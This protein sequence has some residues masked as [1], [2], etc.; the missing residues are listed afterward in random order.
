MQ[1]ARFT[2]SRLHIAITSATGAGSER[3][4]KRRS[5]MQESCGRQH[6]PIS[7]FVFM[8]DAIPR[9]SAKQD[10][11]ICVL[12]ACTTSSRCSPAPRHALHWRC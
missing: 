1:G 6:S 2:F 5:I 11:H 10:M 7:V 12:H 8:L 4:A 9:T 3:S